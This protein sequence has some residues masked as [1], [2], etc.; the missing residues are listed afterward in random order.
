MEK[1][2]IIIFIFMILIPFVSAGYIG[3]TPAKHELY[4]EPFLEQTF[5]FNVFSSDNNRTNEIYTKGELAEYVNISKTSFIGSTSFTVVLKLPGQIEKPGRHRILIGARELSYD[6]NNSGQGVGGLAAIQAPIEIIVPYPG[7]YAEAEFVVK[8][9]SEG[10]NATFN[11]Q[12]H[13]LG[14]ETIFFQPE[15]RIY[16]DKKPMAKKTFSYQVLESKK[17]YIVTDE[18]DT[19]NLMPGQFDVIMSFDYGENITINRVFRIGTLLIN[20]TDYS[21]RFVKGEANKFY[22]EIENLW[23]QPIKNVYSEVSISDQGTIIKRFRLPFKNL[24]PWEKTNLSGL[25]DFT[26]LEPKKYVANIKVLYEGRTTSKL[27]A[28]YVENPNANYTLII[29][30]IIGAVLVLVILFLVIKVKVLKKN[31]KNAKTKKTKKNKK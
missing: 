21:H 18:I 1:R 6:F 20:I 23:N 17:K 9:T 19:A 2:L 7:K 26:D 13:N 12:V 24:E 14:K 4:F 10:S 8:D 16:Q 5:T 27:V 28:I 31:I 3:I 15:I 22:I 29:I 30:G 25:H 11:L